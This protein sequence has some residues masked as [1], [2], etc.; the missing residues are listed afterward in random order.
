MKIS[1][2]MPTNR[3]SYSAIAR[4]FDLASLDPSQFEL[5]VRDNSEN[6]DKRA[7]L[8]KI[9]SPTLRLAIVSNCSAFQNAI[10]ALQ[11]ASGDFVFFLADDDWLSAR[12]LQQLHALAIQTE[13][14]PSVACL[15]G[16][17]VVEMAAATRFFQYRGLDS[18]EPAKRLESYLDANAAN[19]LYYSAVKRSLADFCF[20]FMARLPY[21][22]S[23]HDQLVSLLYLT[24]GR[25]LQ[26]D[27]VV[28]S[29]EL[30]DWESLP[31]SLAKDRAWYVEAGLPVEYDRLQCLFCAME[32]AL[33]LRSGLVGG[34]VAFDRT[35]LSDLW[36]LRYFARF[37]H[38]DRES[39]SAQSPVT[40]AIE[41]LRNK[42]SARP[43]IDLDEL[44]RDVC[45]VLQIA[46][47]AGAK[48]YFDFWST[49]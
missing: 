42:W 38:H 10:D 46:D 15:T 20:A 39:G 33:L 37:K 47:T 21:R 40:G 19:F 7:L 27:R 3:T 28:Y 34:K 29:Y 30:G 44:L 22:F 13:G 14:D 48:R 36:F 2:V 45:E 9:D 6:E 49:L 23:Y 32:G 25:V 1:V 41:R 12:G 31:A 35:P 26:C 5:I 43:L 18:A 16:A 17:Y 11:L 8:R 4:A 24:L